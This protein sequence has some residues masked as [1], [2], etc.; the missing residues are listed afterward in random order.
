MG[1]LRS[2]YDLAGAVVNGV[3]LAP[4]ALDEATGEYV[5]DGPGLPEG[6]IVPDEWSLYAAPL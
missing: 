2:T 1:T 6:D 3:E 4:G 5:W